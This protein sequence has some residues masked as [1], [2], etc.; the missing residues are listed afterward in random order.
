MVFLVAISQWDEL[1]EIVLTQKEMVDGVLH[2]GDEPWVL[3]VSIQ[4]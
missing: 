3:G 1:N 4:C 2:K